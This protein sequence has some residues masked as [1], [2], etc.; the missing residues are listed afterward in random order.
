MQKSQLD[1]C[2]D[3]IM[4]LCTVN[5]KEDKKISQ[6]IEILNK[7]LTLIFNDDNKINNLELILNCPKYSYNIVINKKEKCKIISKPQKLNNSRKKKI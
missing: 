3:E 2:M 4:Q 7:A 1:R 6:T 5:L